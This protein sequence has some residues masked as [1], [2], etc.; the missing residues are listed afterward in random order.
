[1]VTSLLTCKE[2]MG[3]VFWY[4]LV[5]NKHQ[6]LGLKFCSVRVLSLIFVFS[7]FF[8]L[9]KNFEF[10]C[11]IFENQKFLVFEKWWKFMKSGEKFMKVQEFSRILQ[12]EKFMNFHRE[13]FSEIWNLVKKR[14]MF[15]FLLKSYVWSNLRLHGV[16]TCTKPYCSE[17]WLLYGQL[18]LLIFDFLFTVNFF[19]LGHFF[20]HEKLWIFFERI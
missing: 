17:V 19:F 14:K 8:I 16:F 15:F 6:Q 13:R 2:W 12:N 9:K 11:R 7:L 20:F 5:L 3:L 4:Y 10:M 18:I 1:M